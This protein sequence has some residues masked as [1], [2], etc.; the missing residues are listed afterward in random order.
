MHWSKTEKR[1]DIIKRMLEKRVHWSKGS[2]R[3]E[4]IAKIKMNKD[5]STY[6]QKGNTVWKLKKQ[7]PKKEYSCKCCGKMITRHS[8]TGYCMQCHGTRPEFREAR[9]KL[10]KEQI[11]Q[12]GNPNYKSGRFVSRKVECKVCG[13]SMVRKPIFF[14]GRCK[15]CSDNDNLQKA[16]REGK[17]KRYGKDCWNW[18]GG[19][20]YEPYSPE[21]N[22]K[23]KV[24][25]KTRDGYRCQECFRH[26]SEVKRSFA[27][28]HI[29][30]NKKNSNP[31]N[32]ITL[33][34]TCH[35]QTLFNRQK[36]IEY[37][38][39]RMVESGRNLL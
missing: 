33:C 21:F 16:N 29:D 2:K 19:S 11:A 3:D 13:K 5:K 1:N 15:S 34:E 4:T 12:L 22:N 28:H 8:K 23:L 26:Q 38:Q 30:F 32:L 7:V 24:Q 31:N 14:S 20:S 6:L 18:N 17:N 9:R 36:W 39:G 35:N 25:I 10:Y 37:Y 27:V